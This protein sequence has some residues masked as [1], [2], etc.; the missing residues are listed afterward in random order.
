MHHPFVPLLYGTCPPLYRCRTIDLTSAVVLYPIDTIKTRLQA[1]QTK[2]DI[3]ALFQSG[4]G[5]ALYS[6][7]LGNLAGVAPASALFFVAYEPAKR[8]IPEV[9]PAN[10]QYLSSFLAGAIGGI[11]A[12][13]VR[14]PT[15]V[16]K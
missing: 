3:R 5:K 9:L 7:V 1:M 16:V 11:S 4:G 10:L 14:V 8:Y 6:G 2:G 15:E 13:L 12:S